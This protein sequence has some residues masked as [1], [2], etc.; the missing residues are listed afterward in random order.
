[1]PVP[2]KIMR[3]IFLS[4]LCGLFLAGNANAQQNGNERP[5]KSGTYKDGAARLNGEMNLIENGKLLPM[6][7]E[8][9]M[10]NGTLVTPSGMVTQPGKKPV[11]LKEGMA[12]NKQGRIVIFKDDM[13]TPAAISENSSQA[14]YEQNTLI[15]EAPD[16]IIIRKE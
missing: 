12:V 11:K 13:F 9:R 4:I 7:N 2:D 5:E 1:M 10:Q 15:I 8:V 6:Q 3:T 16:T 14:G